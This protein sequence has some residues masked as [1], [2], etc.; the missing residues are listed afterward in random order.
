[1]K[2]KLDENLPHRLSSILAAMGHDVETVH[3]EDLTGRVDGEIWDAA[4][5]E[6]RFLLTQ[7]LDFSDTRKFVPGRHH[8]L[9][10]MRLSRPSRSELLSRIAQL[11]QEEN[12]ESWKRCFVVATDRKIRVQ[13]PDSGPH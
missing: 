7:D 4:Q 10:L 6:E 1:M 3:G 9:L 11:F 12:V 2:L 8:G 13:R 5:Q